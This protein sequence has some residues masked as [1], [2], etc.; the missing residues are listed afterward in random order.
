MRRSAS[1]VDRIL[2]GVCGGSLS[3]WCCSRFDDFCESNGGIQVAA[4][5]VFCLRQR[6][7]FTCTEIV[8]VDCSRIDVLLTNTEAH[9][10]DHCVSVGGRETMMMLF[11]GL[12]C[13]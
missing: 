9:I 6:V 7:R 11:F 10:W 3:T 12:C 4:A 8:Q 13:V 5:S 2:Y 1:A